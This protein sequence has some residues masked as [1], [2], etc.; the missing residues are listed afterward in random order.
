MRSQS[1]LD[2]GASWLALQLQ[3]LLLGE[4]PTSLPYKEMTKRYMLFCYDIACSLLT[5]KDDTQICSC[6]ISVHHAIDITEYSLE[7]ERQQTT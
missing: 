3:R 4:N 2:A 7:L 6:A 5:R 1:V